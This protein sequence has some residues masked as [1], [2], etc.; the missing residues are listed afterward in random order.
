MLHVVFPSVS[1]ENVNTHMDKKKNKT[2]QD[3]LNIVISPETDTQIRNKMLIMKRDHISTYT[4]AKLTEALEGGEQH[5]R[6]TP[7][8]NQQQNTQ[9]L[10]DHS[11]IHNTH[12]HTL[13]AR[14]LPSRQESH[15]LAGCVLHA[16]SPL[17]RHF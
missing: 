9:M 3:Q 8:I 4:M 14:A 6:A 13:I 17:A 5:V 12:T 1:Q 10:N 16:V 7:T 11:S 2:K 15:T